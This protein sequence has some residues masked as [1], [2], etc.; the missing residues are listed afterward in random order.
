VINAFSPDEPITDEIVERLSAAQ[1]TIDVLAFAFT[2]DPVADELI[3]AKERN[4]GVRVV[5][6]NRNTKGTGSEFAK[7]QD[8]GVDI[9]SDGNCYIMHNKVMI[10]DGRTVIT[11]SFNFTRGAQEQNDENVLIIDDPELA[12]RYTEELNES[13]S[14]HSNRHAVDRSLEHDESTARF[15]AS[16]ARCRTALCGAR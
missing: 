2:S 12:A 8:A 15:T 3:V 11:G 7:L 13:I 5:M 16:P 1:Q 9:H 6:E 10:I 4:L 14:K